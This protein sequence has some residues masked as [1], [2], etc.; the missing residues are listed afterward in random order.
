MLEHE[1]IAASRKEIIEN[2]EES[3]RRYDM[4]IISMEIKDGKKCV[5]VEDDFILDNYEAFL[6]GFKAHWCNINNSDEGLNYH[7]ITILLNDELKDFVNVLKKYK[8]KQYIEELLNLC[9]VALNQ[10]MDLIHFGI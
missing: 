3:K 10:K 9:E 4:E 1:F 8:N 2:L 7:G 6:G 5:S